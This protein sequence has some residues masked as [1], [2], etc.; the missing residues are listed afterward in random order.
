M[1]SLKVSV[2]ME[3]VRKGTYSWN[4]RIAASVVD[5]ETGKPIRDFTS[6][7][8]TGEAGGCMRCGG[9]L[10]YPTQMRGEI[11]LHDST[12]SGKTITQYVEITEM[13]IRTIE[14]KKE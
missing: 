9:E 3:R 4:D 1:P 5:Y 10:P 2:V 6:F 11:T 14:A 13:T 8:F 7:R 12:D